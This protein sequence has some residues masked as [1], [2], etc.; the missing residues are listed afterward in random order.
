VVIGLGLAMH[1]GGGAISGMLQAH[2]M[3]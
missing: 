1:L 3:R 2:M